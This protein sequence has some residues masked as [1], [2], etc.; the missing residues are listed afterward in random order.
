MSKT[1][2]KTKAGDLVQ[3]A[4][5]TDRFEVIGKDRSVLILR[6][7]RTGRKTRVHYGK[8]EKI[9]APE[10]AA[11]EEPTLADMLHVEESEPEGIKRKT[12]PPAI[13]FEALKAESRAIWVRRMKFDHAH[14]LAESWIV[15]AKDGRSTRSFN[16]YD[17][18]L[19]RRQKLDKAVRVHSIADD[20][21][22]D[23][24]VKRFEKNGYK[25]WEGAS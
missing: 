6:N 25:R 22:L 14:V 24:R 18:S 5:E 21:D 11:P 1:A 9:L 12:P 2:P 4:D 3:V 13:D 20:A 7:S 16:T 23:R 8:V 10:E 15:V 17:R 19:G